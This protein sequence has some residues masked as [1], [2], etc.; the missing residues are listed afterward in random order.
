[1]LI[2]QERPVNSD[3]ELSELIAGTGVRQITDTVYRPARH[4][5]AGSANDL[6]VDSIEQERF[7]QDGRMVAWSYAPGDTRETGSG[8]LTYHENSVLLKEVEYDHGKL[9]RAIANDLDQQGRLSRSELVIYERSGEIES[10][11]LT[12]FVYDDALPLISD[13]IVQGVP[14]EENIVFYQQEKL[15][16][17]EYRD[18]GGE[19]TA[20]VQYE[21]DQLGRLATQIHEVKHGVDDSIKHQFGYCGNN[22]HPSEL[23]TSFLD[24]ENVLHRQTAKYDEAGNQIEFEFK[25]EHEA[26]TLKRKFDPMGNVIEQAKDGIITN[27]EYEYDEKGNWISKRLLRDQRTVELVE[28]VIEYYGA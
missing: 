15:V 23:I 4:A 5:D 11:Y 3:L 1:M 16:R 26:Y 12:S 2:Y 10:V 18:A 7:D 22:P 14:S 27:W 21:Y 19:V 25:G 17:E 8:R 9:V 20:V 13:P 24:G 28:R 6:L